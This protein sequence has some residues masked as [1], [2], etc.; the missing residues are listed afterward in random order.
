MLNH[1]QLIICPFQKTMKN[2][3]VCQRSTGALLTTKVHIV[4]YSKFVLK[5]N[6][7]FHLICLSSEY[8]IIYMCIY[9]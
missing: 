2:G 7:I 6:K 9:I 8:A 1:S 3:N 4:V 5:F